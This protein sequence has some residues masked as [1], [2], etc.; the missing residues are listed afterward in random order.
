L[1]KL[2]KI[3]DL[4]PYPEGSDDR[5]PLRIVA[6]NHHLENQKSVLDVDHSPMRDTL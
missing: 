6:L 2:C 5:F 1:H 4:L 3:V